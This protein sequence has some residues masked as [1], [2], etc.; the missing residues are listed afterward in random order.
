MVRRRVS[1]SSAD[2]DL[3]R[4]DAD[5]DQIVFVARWNSHAFMIMRPRNKY[6]RGYEARFM[7]AKLETHM[8]VVYRRPK[9]ISRRPR[10]NG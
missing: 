8:R 9:D 1:K 2:D 3:A 10:A 6:I 7:Q 4:L 5:K